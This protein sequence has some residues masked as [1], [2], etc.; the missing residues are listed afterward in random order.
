MCSVNVCKVLFLFGKMHR[1]HCDTSSNYVKE[2]P[3]IEHLFRFEAA[4][5]RPLPRVRVHLYTIQNSCQT[6][7]GD[8]KPLFINELE[9]LAKTQHV[10]KIPKTGN[11]KRWLHETR[12]PNHNRNIALEPIPRNRNT[13]PEIGM[14]NACHICHIYLSI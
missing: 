2:L 6:I 4:T 8:D 9:R 10:A 3:F 11:K 7:V 12:S 13:F 1:T 14:C 5:G